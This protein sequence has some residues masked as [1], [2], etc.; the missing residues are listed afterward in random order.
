MR[1]TR[2]H[3]NWAHVFPSLSCHSAFTSRTL[4]APHSMSRVI[5][6]LKCIGTSTMSPGLI[7][8]FP[9]L[10]NA[11][12]ANLMSCPSFHLPLPYHLSP[13]PLSLSPLRSY[14]TTSPTVSNDRDTRSLQSAPQCPAF[15]NIPSPTHLRRDILSSPFLDQFI[16]PVHSRHFHQNNVCTCVRAAMS[17]NWL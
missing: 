9:S 5:P 2:P 7:C 3:R 17:P 15:F 16:F 13:L 11:R 10:S 6:A 4:P 12:T 8:H 14:A 1:M